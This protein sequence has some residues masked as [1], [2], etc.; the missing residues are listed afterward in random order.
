MAMP[1]I[2]PT[3]IVNWAIVWGTWIAV[4]VLLEGIALGEPQ[5]GDS[6]S[7]NYR[8]VRY[9]SVGK[10]IL[11]PLS[12]WA[13]YHLNLKRNGDALFTWKDVVWLGLG[14]AWAIVE[15]RTGRTF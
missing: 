6:F 10:F 14:L 1:S 11:L 15:A 13:L 8:A 3:R 5:H 7:E 4:W 12:V 2:N 9:D